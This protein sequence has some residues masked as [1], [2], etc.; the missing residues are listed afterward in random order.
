MHIHLDG[1]RKHLDGF[2]GV[3]YSFIITTLSFINTDIFSATLVKIVIVQLQK[4]KL[5]YNITSVEYVII[6]TYIFGTCHNKYLR[7]IREGK[8]IGEDGGI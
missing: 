6:N 3:L 8:M 5:N 2:L 7:E 1:I 4:L